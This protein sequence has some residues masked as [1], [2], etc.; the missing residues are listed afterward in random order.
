[1]KKRWMK[2]LALGLMS[3]LTLTACSNGGGSKEANAQLTEEEKNALYT[4]VG[5]YPITNEPITM[6][7]FQR[8]VPNI[9]DYSTNEF[10]KYMEEK[11]NITWKFESATS[12]A[13]TEKINLLMAGGTP[14]DV[15]IFDT[16]D[17]AKF[18]VKE[19]LLLPIEDLIEENMPNYK[20]A[21]EEVPA[22]KGRTTATDGHIY[23]IATVNQCYHC[24][25]A[26]KMWVNTM[27]L[28]KMGM[29]VPTTTEEF[30]EVCRKFLEINPKGVA[31]AGSNDGWF[32]DPTPFLMNAF[33]LDPGYDTD[34]KLVLN[35]EGNVD[36]IVNKDE[37]KEGLKFLNELYEMGAIYEGTFTQNSGQLRNLMAQEGEPVLFVPAGTISD[38]ID[39]VSN[40]ETY[41]HYKT[42]APIKGPSGLRQATYYKH[43]G[44]GATSFAITKDCKY[45]EAALR[46]IDYMFTLEG[47]LTSQFGFEGE[48]W[49][50]AEEGQVGLDGRPATY[51]I[52]TA[53]S[54]EPQNKD[55]Q[56]V[57][58]SYRTADMRMGSAT[59]EG[60]DVGSP[61]GIEELLLQE[62]KNNY[63]PYPQPEGNYDILPAIKLTAEESTEIQTISVE[64]EK[65]A[66]EMRVAFISGT[67]DIDAEWD[68]YIKGLEK[69]Q[70]SKYIE[71][72]NNAYTR[73][74]K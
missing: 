71:V 58:V 72:Y 69:L 39:S 28:E 14:P 7:M 12:D 65:Y 52:L 73:Q 35:P 63:E 45:P 40:N 43:A 10:T 17:E 62:T 57:G 36:V 33:I 68:D 55:W 19:G 8:I 60:R 41:G 66:E 23:N 59:E 29:D 20:K 46:W 54:S 53:Y 3:S 42:I 50:Y 24:T 37:Y 31:I 27:W 67:K 34:P 5:T 51:E 25:Y 74:Y 13:V 44:I 18:G 61:E 1:M 9:I 11:T 21:M 70:L 2:W 22:I 49:K 56:D 6:T 64:L 16:P 47:T 15:F 48:D 4:E 38:V 30:K 32:Q 26:Q